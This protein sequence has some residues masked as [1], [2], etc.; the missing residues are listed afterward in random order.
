[1]PEP[2][3]LRPLLVK[4]I[5]YAGLRPPCSLDLGRALEN[6]SRY[7]RS[8][9]TWMLSA[10]VL[11]LGQFDA[12]VHYLNVFDKENPLRISALG[13]ATSNPDEFCQELRKA[14]DR[15]KSFAN[16]PGPLVPV[17]E[18]LEMALPREGMNAEVVSRIHEILAGTNF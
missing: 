13:P 7:V 4:S 1:M 18:Q 12:A 9:D 3:S 8:A 17:I 6:Q 10:F 16:I 2:E 15:T 11:P 5:D 14:A